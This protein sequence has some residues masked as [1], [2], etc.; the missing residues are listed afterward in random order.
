MEDILDEQVP[1]Q[2]F[3][4]QPLII[5]LFL[6]AVGIRLFEIFFK[7]YSWSYGSEFLLAGS[8]SIFLTGTIAFFTKA[9]YPS[10][11]DLK[12]SIYFGF[13]FIG[14]GAQL[15][16]FYHLSQM[17][18]TPIY[19][20]SLRPLFELG[21]ILLLLRYYTRNKGAYLSIEVLKWPF[22]LTVPLMTVG[23]IFKFQSWPYASEMITLATLFFF[24][25]STISFFWITSS[26][27]LLTRGFPFLN[28]VTANLFYFGSLF[29]IQ[30]WP[31]A[32]ELLFLA[33]IFILISSILHVFSH[34]RKNKE[35]T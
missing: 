17:S 10:R 12:I 6:F 33:A 13:F 16:H 30:S 18:F 8:F 34:I 19:I 2:E 25:T 5:T 20:R 23:L 35:E 21:T 7:L 9:F 14:F 24:I 11:G 31:F 15:I 32:S 27:K 28:V 4:P 1:I 3:K 26:K 22:N 29:K